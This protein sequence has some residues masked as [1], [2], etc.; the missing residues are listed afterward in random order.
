MKNVKTTHQTIRIIKPV[1]TDEIEWILNKE[2]SYT[3][4]K[5]TKFFKILESMAVEILNNRDNG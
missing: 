2:Y 1:T 4:N 5:E 3:H